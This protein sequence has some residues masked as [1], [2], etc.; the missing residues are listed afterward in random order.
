MGIVNLKAES[1][2]AQ[3][4]VLFGPVLA[5]VPFLPAVP[6]G[7]IGLSVH[8]SVMSTEVLFQLDFSRALGALVVLCC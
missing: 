6:A 4:F 5:S 8:F 3:F 2:G 7:E 1:S